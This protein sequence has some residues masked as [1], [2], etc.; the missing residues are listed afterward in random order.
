MG[1]KTREQTDDV[2]K[3]ATEIEAKFSDTLKQ[4]EAKAQAARNEAQ[5]KASAKASTIEQSYQDALKDLG[6]DHKAA[7]DAEN[8]RHAQEIASL[9]KKIGLAKSA[10][11]SNLAKLENELDESKGELR[12]EKSADLSV[13]EAGMRQAIAKVEDAKSG[14][15]AVAEQERMEGLAL[16]DHGTPSEGESE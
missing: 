13:V 7:I 11:L 3:Q 9:K 2:R 10:R 8:K 5:S 1:K 12:R 4:I 15:I 16:L 14:E 6:S